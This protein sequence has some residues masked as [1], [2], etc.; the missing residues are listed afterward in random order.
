MFINYE[1]IE[2]YLVG[3]C[4]LSA[5]QAAWVSVGEYM[6]RREA[7]EKLQQLEWERCRWMAWS[8]ITPFSGKKGPK[9]PSQWIKFPWEKPEQITAIKI[10]DNQV[11]ALDEIFKD[12]LARKSNG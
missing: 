6:Q 12:F 3:Y 5:R 11:T 10:D 2:A 7:C 9:T 8:I 1:E 4:G